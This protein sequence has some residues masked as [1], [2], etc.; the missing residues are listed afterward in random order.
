MTDTASDD[1]EEQ[2][3]E[4]AE[5]VVTTLIGG[6]EALNEQPVAATSKLRFI[7]LTDNPALRSN[8]WDMRVVEPLFP[9]DPVR[10]QRHLKLMAHEYLPEFDRSLYI[11]NAVLLKA[12]PEE[13]LEHCLGE[14][15]F[16][17][18]AHS[19]RDTVL[20]EFLCVAQ[21]D[22]DDRSRIFEQLNHYAVAYSDA[23]QMRPIWAGIIMRDHRREDIRRL[24][25]TWRDHVFRYSRRDQLSFSVACR[26]AG[27]EVDLLPEDNFE[28]WFHRWPDRRERVPNV[29][30]RAPDIARLP[31]KDFILRLQKEIETNAKEVARLREEIRERDAWASRLERSLGW[32]LT[33]PAR[34]V[35]KAARGPH[36]ALKNS[37]R[38]LRGREPKK[39]S[40]SLSANARFFAREGYL[41]PVRLFT[42]AQC[43][44][45]LRHFK[46]HGHNVDP[47]WPK[48]LAVRDPFYHAVATRPQIVERLKPLLGEDIVLWGVSVIERDPGQ[49][50]PFHTDIESSS[51]KGGCISVW[52]G[53]ENT[54]RRSALT[55]VGRSH[56]VGRPLQQEA[57]KR[58]VAR[59]AGTDRMIRNWC[60]EAGVQ[61]QMVQ[62]DMADGDGLIFDGRLW[63]GS[64]NRGRTR[65][66]AL[67]LQYARADVPVRIQKYGNV[68][69]PFEFTSKSP[70][71]LRVSGFTGTGKL[72]AAQEPLDTV[73][74]SGEGYVADEKGWI[75][76]PI[77][78]G[79]TPNVSSIESHVSVLSPDNSPHPPHCHLDEELLIVLEGEAEIVIPEGADPAGARIER[80]RPGSFVYYPAYQYHTIRNVSASPV[81]YLMFRW[82]AA[83]KEAE[84]PLPTLVQHANSRDLDHSQ[85]GQAMRLLFEG[86]TGFLAKLHCHETVMGAGAGYPAHEDAHDVAI[87]VLEGAIE[88]NGKMIGPGGM[89]FHPAATSHGLINPG[90]GPARYLVFEFHRGA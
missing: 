40:R 42:K 25:K 72:P 80:M 85:Q 2:R 3:P 35:A 6:Y 81:T 31:P 49:A 34:L 1:K 76:Y 61:A 5:C 29:G 78:H 37:V 56:T 22:L 74:R 54:S 70:R 7:C 64:D 20:D 67:L 46:E 16:A 57:R 47:E 73:I 36:L 89:A 77:L 75:P 12:E 17:A 53:L 63:H 43:A 52:I 69:W 13:I 65:R 18:C 71:K 59:G 68:D 10:S 86:E 48:D 26:Q 38:R 90:D 21:L 66:S 87:V 50:H 4:L 24:M 82:Q 19:Y 88:A 14:S 27:V 60:R 51:T 79:A 44:M 23:L 33:A 84:R 62:P 45:I 15:G 55:L 41:G 28:S 30:L 58:G 83:P 11:D 8:S 9:A 32:R 39:P